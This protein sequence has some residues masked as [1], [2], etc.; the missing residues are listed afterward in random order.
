M[1]APDTLPTLASRLDLI[2]HLEYRDRVE[3]KPFMYAELAEVTLTI[4]S[5][6]DTLVWTEVPWNSAW[7]AYESNFLLRSSFLVPEMWDPSSEAALVLPIG[8]AE[9]FSHPEALVFIDGTPLAGCDRHHQELIL[10]VLYADGMEHQ[11]DLLGWAGRQRWDGSDP[12]MGLW[13]NTCF[14]VRIDASTRACQHMYGSAGC[15]LQPGHRSSF[16]WGTACCGMEALLLLDFTEPFDEASMPRSQLRFKCCVKR[17]RDLI[18]VPG[19]QLKQLVRAILTWR[20]CG[21]W[22]RPAPRSGALSIPCFT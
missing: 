5:N 16:V 22:I 18:L 19:M 9:D 10:P 20:G 1:S 12:G 2:R 14:L 21:H 6:P 15:Y 4:P 8:T 17:S 11:L 13:M 3:L 7:T